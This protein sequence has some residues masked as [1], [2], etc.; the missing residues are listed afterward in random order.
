MNN[1]TLRPA[2]GFGILLTA[3]LICLALTGIGQSNQARAADR[4]PSGSAVKAVSRGAIKTKYQ[5]DAIVE[6]AEMGPVKL[7]LKAWTDLTVLDA[8]THGAR[9]KKG[10]VLVRLDTEKLVE[11]IK[12]LEQ[13]QP[14]A[15][16]SLELALAEQENLKQ[17]TP[18]KLEAAQRSQRVVNEDYDYF[19]RTNR[20][21][22]EKSA[23]FG[24]KNAEQR[25]ENVAEELAQLQKMYKADDLTEETEEIILKRQKFAVESAE[26]GLEATRLNAELSLKTS[27]PREHESLQS[28]KRDQDLALALADQTLPKALT[29][30]GLE[31]EKLKRDQRK[32][33][34]KLADLKKDLDAIT[35]RAPL[36]GIVY[37]G[38]CENGKWT[39][40]AGVAKKLIPTGKLSVNEVFI[41]V[42][43]SEKL[44]LKAVVPEPEL[45][46]L[47]R[48]LEGKASPVSAPDKKLDV[49]LEEIGY[50]PL[51]GGGFEARLSVE[52]EKGVHLMPGMTCKITFTDVPKPDV[53]LAPKDAVFGEANQKHVFVRQKDG[54]HEKRTVKAGESDDKM[55]EILEGLSEGDKILL[56]KPE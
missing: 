3:F 6:S 42:V 37:Y 5:M 55:T 33:E 39:T 22:K 10:D 27:I 45:S 49:K 29:K 30:K 38:A 48:G 51:P 23:R 19:Q 20:A 36:D 9:V 8:V 14:A 13:D 46:R 2:L 44:L 53:L 31:I 7:E 40:G 1:H 24:V 17:T 56:K 35:V 52:K 18:L 4:K 25:L 28:Q 50:I 11:Q 47:K 41:T 54:T 16:V 21:Q 34:K 32:A 43:N 12:D 26:Y 15:A